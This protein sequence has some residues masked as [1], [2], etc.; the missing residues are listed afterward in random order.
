M[1]DEKLDRMMK[2]RQGMQKLALAPVKSD[3]YVSPLNNAVNIVKGGKQPVVNENMVLKGTTEKINTK[4]MQKLISGQDR[5]DKVAKII[6]ARRLA[7]LGGIAGDALKKVPMI[8]GIAAGLGTLL[9]TGDASAASQ[10]ALP[11]V[12]DSDD[13]GPTPG[14]LE[15]KLENGTITEDEMDKLLKGMN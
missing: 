6:E 5:V 8:G 1:D 13:L 7:K 11:L 10:A 12:G 9:T 14:S 15:S 3:D 2:F 4:P